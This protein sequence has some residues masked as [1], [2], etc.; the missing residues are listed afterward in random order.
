[1]GIAMRIAEAAG[2]S[3]ARGVRDGA[4]IEGTILGRSAAIVNGVP[5]SAEPLPPGLHPELSPWAPDLFPR[6]PDSAGTG[7]ADAYPGVAGAT[8]AREGHPRQ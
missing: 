5:G 1:M 2:A 6:A 7:L 4:A 3:G 8:E